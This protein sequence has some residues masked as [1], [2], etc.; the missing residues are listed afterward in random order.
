MVITEKLLISKIDD[1]LENYQFYGNGPLWNRTYAEF[2]DII[3]LQ[4][5]KAKDMFT[6][7]V[8]VASKFVIET[9]WGL[10]G[11]DMVD[12]P[13]STVRA[14]L[15]E[16]MYGRDVW[17]NLSSGGAVDEVSSAIQEVAMPFLQLNHNIDH[18]IQLLEN[19]LAAKRYPPGVI[20]LA[21]LHYQKG[22]SDR[23]RE[24][25][26]SMKLTGAWSKKASDILDA[27][28]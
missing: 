17:W 27:L 9:C 21:L 16:L 19:D 12:E 8:G 1:L 25:F 4:F 18:M 6:I 11:E 15:G 10:N 20:Y 2:V 13:S 23:C 7:N 5:S 26:E 22:E 3:D 28:N 14:R 24:M